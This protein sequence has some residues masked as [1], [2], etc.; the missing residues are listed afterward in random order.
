MLGLAR[1]H[2][3]AVAEIERQGQQ[4]RL[5]ALSGFLTAVGGALQAA[6][7]KAFKIGKAFSIAGAIVDT[8]R[9]IT[10]ALATYAPPQSYMH[11][12]TTA[13]RG[14]AAVAAMKGTSPG[15]GGGSGGRAAASAGG[16]GGG[17]GG[18]TAAQP[19]NKTYYNVSLTGGSNFGGDQI[20]DLI[21]RINEE[22]EDGAVL[23]GIRVV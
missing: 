17:G 2:Q 11:A 15:G 20:R 8:Y 22:I 19:M 7:G 21:S 18:G 10:K 6:G 16:G 12:A 4:A 9:G 13:A 5:V 3:L 1:Q 14:F 23:G